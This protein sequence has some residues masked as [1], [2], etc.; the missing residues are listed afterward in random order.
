MDA[1]SFLLSSLIFPICHTPSGVGAVTQ[2]FDKAHRYFMAVV[3]QVWPSEERGH[4]GRHKLK[5][6]KE[7]ELDNRLARDAMYSAMFLGRMYLRGEGKPGKPDFRKARIFLERAVE[8]GV[9][10]CNRATGQEREERTEPACLSLAR[11][12][13]RVTTC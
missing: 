11:L 9:S 4:L 8:I 10:V 2:S 7:I 1:P 12:R 3:R 13:K 5:N 6:G